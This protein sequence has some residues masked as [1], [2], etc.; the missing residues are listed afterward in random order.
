MRFRLN[1]TQDFHDH[2]DLHFGYLF[3]Q[4]V[5]P[6]TIER[7][8][9]EIN[10]RVRALAEYPLRYPVD[11]VQT[12]KLGIETRKMNIGDHI[13]FY[14]VDD[15]AQVVNTVAFMHGARREEL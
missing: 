11:P 14:Q 12:K 6:L 9:N 1:K 4:Q 5:D 3:D 13:V 10:R 7:W 2:L 15:A 8:A